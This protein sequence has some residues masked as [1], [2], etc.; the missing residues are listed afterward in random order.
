MH[1]KSQ[2][3][4][5]ANTVGVFQLQTRISFLFLLAKYLRRFL[6]I[7]RTHSFFTLLYLGGTYNFQCHWARFQ[8][9]HPYNIL[10]FVDNC[11]AKVAILRLST[12]ISILFTSSIFE[13]V[14]TL[15]IIYQREDIL[16]FCNKNYTVMYKEIVVAPISFNK[17]GV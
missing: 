17:Q 4:V 6:L 8:R 15:D 1:K 11:I 13:L 14:L 5:A 3:Y 12:N 7:M 9:S 16:Y 10:I 2:D